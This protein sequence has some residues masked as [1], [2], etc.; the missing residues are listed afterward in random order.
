M[1]DSTAVYPRTTAPPS[2]PHRLHR[3]RR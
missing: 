1:V 3:T 2:S